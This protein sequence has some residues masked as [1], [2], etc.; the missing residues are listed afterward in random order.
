[1]RRA[2]RDARQ[3][4]HLYC[5]LCRVRTRNGCYI[6]ISTAMNA[7]SILSDTCLRSEGE[8]GN[9]G[10][11]YKVPRVQEGISKTSVST[12]CTEECTAWQVARP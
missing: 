12:G 7:I 5:E 9:A 8:G 1:M 6:I 4:K 10:C 3:V 11:V 2:E